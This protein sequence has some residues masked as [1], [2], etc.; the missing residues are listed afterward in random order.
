MLRLTA[1]QLLQLVL[2]F[3]L[4]PPGF[5]KRAKAVVQSRH[6]FQPS[7]ALWKPTRAEYDFSHVF[8]ANMPAANPIV[9]LEG[10]FTSSACMDIGSAFGSM[11]SSRF[12]VA[13]SSS[14]AL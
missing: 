2:A 12:G 10:F 6:A 9:S 5:F 3:A 8:I 13:G 4:M 11:G 14:R 7:S 1:S